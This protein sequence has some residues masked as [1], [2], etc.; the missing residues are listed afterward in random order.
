MCVHARSVVSILCDLM[1]CSP[2]SSS[3]HGIFWARRLEWVA[4]SFT[5]GSNM[6][7]LYRQADS[8]P[9]RHLGSPGHLEG[10][11]LSRGRDFFIGLCA[12]IA[13]HSGFSH[14]NSDLFSFSSTQILRMGC[15]V[16][17]NLTILLGQ[18]VLCR[19]QFLPG[20]PNSSS[21]R[22][23]PHSKGISSKTLLGHY[24]CSLRNLH[25]SWGAVH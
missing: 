24:P 5:Q 22:T 12:C 10:P 16:P 21:K 18:V 14:D 15:F 7:L 1:D 23:Y 17:L 2:S 20:K 9:L 19:H 13:S 8:L 4:I 11:S 25:L 6:C 3:V